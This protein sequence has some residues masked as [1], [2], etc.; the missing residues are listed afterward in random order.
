M[1]KQVEEAAIAASKSYVGQ[2]N[3]IAIMGNLGWDTEAEVLEK[4]CKNTLK[5]VDI[6]ADK[7]LAVAFEDALD[8]FLLLEL[9]RRMLTVLLLARA[10]PPS[11]ASECKFCVLI[12]PAVPGPTNVRML[13]LPSDA[14]DFTRAKL[15]L[16]SRTELPYL[17]GP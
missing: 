1:K 10:L 13:L 8:A 11:S 14:I 2:P 3:R 9:C 6:P 5:E 7:V 12:R 16:L 4:R 15:C 17:S